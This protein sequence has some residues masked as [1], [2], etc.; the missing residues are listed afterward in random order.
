MIILNEKVYRFCNLVLFVEKKI[1]PIKKGMDYE[2]IAEGI[3]ESYHNETDVYSEAIQNAVDSIFESKVKNPQLIITLDKTENFFKIKDNGLGMSSGDLLGF[4]LGRTHK[5][6]KRLSGGLG[7]GASY[8]LYNSDKIKI[9][10]VKNGEK[11]IVHCDDAYKKTKNHE[12]AEFEIDLE[13]ATKEKNYTEITILGENFSFNEYKTIDEFIRMLRTKTAVGYTKVL[14]NKSEEYNVDVEINFIDWDSGGS[15]KKKTEKTPF[16]YIHLAEIDGVSSI[17]YEDVSTDEN[18]SNSLLSYKDDKKMVW[19]TLSNPKILANNE[20]E[21]G[22]YVSIR[23]IPQNVRITLPR[24]GFSGYWK[25]IFMLINVEDAQIDLGRKTI[26]KND[27]NKIR[28]LAKET[29]NKLIKRANLFI[30]VESS[31]ELQG[32]AIDALKEEVLSY[33]DLNIPNIKFLKKPAKEQSVIAIF[34]ELVSCGKLGNYS[35]LFSSQ[36]SKYDAIIKYESELSELG[37]EKREEFFKSFRSVKDKPTK[38]KQTLTTEFKLDVED[39]IKDKT[40]D[41][42]EVDLII[43]WDMSKNK[44]KQGWKFE[45]LDK[46]DQIY[47]GAMHKLSNNFNDSAH[48]IL[49]K[50]FCQ[51][52]VK[53]IKEIMHIVKKD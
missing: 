43:A 5:T 22:I 12:E 51:E 28:D 3:I 52:E 14:F 6:G 18:Y 49:L 32:I 42:K 17:D 34:H 15:K 41:I 40:K 1:I 31:S 45:N 4:A 35:C 26:S 39:F 23:G 30:A 37:K 16:R 50:D 20:I 11:I 46:K 25:N 8:L 29:F 47:A 48:V 44:L 27:E 38:F 19:A 7:V 10:S 2:K 53:K 21:P 33:E 13:E 9:E 24:T 36:E